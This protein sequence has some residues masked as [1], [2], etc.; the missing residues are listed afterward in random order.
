MIAASSR[1]AMARRSRLTRSS[2]GFWAT[3]AQLLVRLRL[4]FLAPFKGELG[5]SKKFDSAL[6]AAEGGWLPPDFGAGKP[7]PNN[8]NG[9]KPPVG[10][11]PPQQR[12]SW[13]ASLAAKLVLSALMLIALIAAAFFAPYWSS[14]AAVPVDGTFDQ[15][16]VVFMSHGPRLPLLRGAIRHYSH[17]PSASSV[18]VVWNDGPSPD[19]AMLPS[20]V[21]VRIRVEATNSLSNRFKPDP[22]IATRAVLSIDDDIRIPCADIEAAFAD[23][24]RAPDTM[25]GFFPRLIEGHPVP[26]FQGESY[27]VGRRHYNS[28]LTGAAFLDA[29]TAFPAYWAEAVAPARAV[30]DEVFNGEDLLMNFVLASQ[31]AAQGHT[32]PPVR[33]HQPR[34]S[35][36][37]GGSLCLAGFRTKCGEKPPCIHFGLG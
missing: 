24:R 28:V 6:K 20:S 22:A 3:W 18:L 11:L 19:L 4:F 37:M 14:A 25:V 29:T 9:L 23:W 30:V 27:A 10:P 5:R 13:T 8:V 7:P 26:A 36:G 34:V 33:F 2:S 31:R 16:T 17:C 32:T 1:F 21:P 15:Y 12:K 35:Q